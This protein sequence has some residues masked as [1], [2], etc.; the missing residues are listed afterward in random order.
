MAASTID[1]TNTPLALIT[2]DAVVRGIHTTT[3]KIDLKPNSLAAL[4]DETPPAHLL[5]HKIFE[6][7]AG[8]AM[9]PATAGFVTEAI[10]N[11]TGFK[12]ERRS[13]VTDNGLVDT[14]TGVAK[15]IGFTM[16]APFDDAGGLAGVY[17]EAATDIIMT[18]VDS[19]AGD[20]TAPTTGVIV[21]VLV[22]A[23]IA[24]ALSA[25]YREG[26]GTV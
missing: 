21:L 23:D 4:S 25:G 12:F 8:V 14:I 16:G 1:L 15:G 18:L 2:S 26:D 5:D 20:D 17:D 9:L 22:W 10:N 19:G 24:N 6:L 13:G 7:P 11:I 3:I